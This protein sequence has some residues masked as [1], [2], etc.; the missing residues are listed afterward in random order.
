MEKFLNRLIPFSSQGDVLTSW[1]IVILIVTFSIT[2]LYLLFVYFR[3]STSLSKE[4]ISEN[5]RLKGLWD[6]Y[7]STLCYYG[8]NSKKQTTESSESYFNEYYVLNKYVNLKVINNISNSLVGIGILG[9]FVGLTY[10]I[11][12]S[13]FENT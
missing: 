4:K 11:T 7:S 12:D 9:T 6:I 3:I 13:N 10:G 1:W 2:L 5:K 8:D